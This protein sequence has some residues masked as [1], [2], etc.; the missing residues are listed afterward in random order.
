MTAL[1]PDDTL[2]QQ[3]QQDNVHFKALLDL[4]SP[5]LYFNQEEKQEIYG[6]Y[7]DD[8]EDENKSGGRKKKKRKKAASLSSLS[9]TQIAEL[10]MK[11]ETLG[12]KKKLNKKEKKVKQSQS[13]PESTE[14]NYSI[15]DKQ[16]NKKKSRS[17]S[18][19]KK[20]KVF[21]R[22]ESRLEELKE[23][24]RLKL[25]QIK[26]HKSSGSNVN[27]Q[28]IKKLKRQ[29]KKVKS[30][31]KNK[32][33]S[34]HKTQQ[35]AAA[36]NGLKTQPQNKIL[37]T[38]G[39]PIKSKFDFSI[40]SVG[41]DKHKSSDLQGRDYKRL[42]EKVE[43]QKERVEKLK[44]KDPEAGRKLEKN[45]QWQNVFSKAKGEKVKDDPTLL[46]KAV[47]R[48]EKIKEKKQKQWGERVK[49]VEDLKKKRQD[50]RQ[51]NIDKRKD[52]KK[53]KKRKLMIKKGRII[54]GF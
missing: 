37:N 45:I 42:L 50:K 43:K 22:R 26:A 17:S 51:T 29:E 4:I 12:E 5:Q 39:Q 35:M 54:P 47:K 10:R 20:P 32:D 18:T 14:E 9:V 3:A 24:L 11:G 27:S 25:E 49:A 15:S 7:S 19:K 52:S 31:L 34:N 53:D 40:I 1:D 23:K 30:Q 8:E 16:T 33:K 6:N 2:L 13:A 44:E 48:K 36:A 46:K 21:Q 28:E 38:N 41:N